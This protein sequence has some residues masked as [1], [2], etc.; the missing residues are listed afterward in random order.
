MDVNDIWRA[1]GR[2]GENARR[3]IE[4]GDGLDNISMDDLGSIIHNPELYGPEAV[5][6]AKK[7][8]A[9]MDAQAA[10]SARTD[11][12]VNNKQGGYDESKF[13]LGGDENYANEEAARLKGQAGKYDYRGDVYEGVAADYRDQGQDAWGNAMNADKRSA[14]AYEDN[15]LSGNEEMGRG[16][17]AGSTMLARE[18]AMGLAPSQAEAALQQG[19]N[20]ASAEQ[21]SQAGGA[22]GLAALS[23]AQNNASASQAALH[24]Q[25]ATES[26]RLRA[27][28]MAEARGLY[29]S[30]S[31]QLRQGDQGRLQ[32]GNQMSQF[33]AGLN[34]RYGERMGQMS[35]H[36]GVLGN[37]ASQTALGNAGMGR[38]YNQDA[39][40]VL[41]TQLNAGVQQQGVAQA[42]YENSRGRAER[43]AAAATAAKNRDE[44]QDRADDANLREGATNVTAKAFEIGGGLMGSGPKKT[45]N[46]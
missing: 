32:I 4:G 46:K 23:Q 39:N 22:R 34:E 31:G 11:N 20:R 16:E 6:A 21:T 40:N 18:A 26:A 9:E 24:Q 25:T 28:E 42:G 44:D 43:N 15:A 29:G 17:Q 41:G 13:F 27:Q 37:A 8:A 7:R 14:R 33:N 19:F 12:F 2:D 5:A 36:A 45:E 38:G 35:D 1:G 30:L 10:E 3:L